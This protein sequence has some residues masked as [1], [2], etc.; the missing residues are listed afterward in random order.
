MNSGSRSSS[1]F[2][3]AE[4]MRCCMS[5]ELRAGWNPLVVSMEHSL[6]S[7]TP[8]AKLVRTHF[9][10]FSGITPGV[11]AMPGIIDFS[12]TRA[13]SADLNLASRVVLPMP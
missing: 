12:L 7:V 3:S 13:L 1:R 8:L 4:A 6:D 5:P 9:I 11:Y 10:Q 2:S